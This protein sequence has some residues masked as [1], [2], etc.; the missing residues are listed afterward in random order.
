[1]K[2]IKRVLLAAA[3]VVVVGVGS[4][5]VYADSPIST[6]KNT[7]QNTNIENRD[8]WHEE[9]H[10]YR[11]EELKK[12]VEN[13]EIT[14][15]EAKEWEDHFDYMEE[16]HNKTRSN[17]NWSQGRGYGRCGSGGYGRGHH[18]MMRNY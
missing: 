10:S 1:M 13:K 2:N 16:F 12:A 6:S 7:N 9:M 18:G 3:L 5:M 14:A 15:E 4:L 11:K 8:K 17:S